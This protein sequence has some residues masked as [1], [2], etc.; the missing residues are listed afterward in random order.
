LLP[1]TSGNGQTL[2]KGY[3]HYLSLFVASDKRQ[4]MGL[5][6]ILSRDFERHEKHCWCK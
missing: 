4:Q 6:L 3:L 2:V 1:P 5:L